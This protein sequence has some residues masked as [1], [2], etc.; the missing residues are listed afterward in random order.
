MVEDGKHYCYYSEDNNLLAAYNSGNADSYLVKDGTN[1]YVMDLNYD[2]TYFKI[3]NYTQSNAEKEGTDTDDPDNYGEVLVYDFSV[4]HNEVAVT[5]VSLTPSNLNLSENH[6]YQYTASIIPTAATN[7]G[8]SYSSSNSSIVEVN[9]DGIVTAKSAG[10]ATV[11]VTTEEGAFKATSI[12][13]VY[14]D[15]K[16][17]NLALNKPVT[18]TGTHD[19]GN[20]VENLVDGL[21]STRWSVSGFPQSAIV[22]LGKNYVVESTEVVCYSDRAYQYT[23]SI[24][25]TEDGVYSEIVDRSS[26][27]K[28]GTESSPIFD[29]FTGVEGRFVKITVTGAA[30]YSGSWVSLLEFRV[31]EGTTLSTEAAIA[32]NDII[33]IWPNPANDKIQISN[34][35]KFDVLKVYDQLGK[36]IINQSLQEDYID[37]SRLKSGVYNFKFSNDTQTVYK[38]VIKK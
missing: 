20:K 4:V 14:E 33:K 7:T 26:N 21:T 30:E 27:A 9:S 2:E 8:V 19:A 12:V 31:F 32:T 35:Q 38:R 1:D 23:V 34:T 18:G 3:G 24:S 36:L 15:T 5:G 6:S 13:T 17:L 25:D 22:D 10:T 28:A 37:V 29:V 16:G 11:T